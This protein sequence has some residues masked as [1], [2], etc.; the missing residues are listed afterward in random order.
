MSGGKGGSSTSE[1]TIP[2]YSEAA[3]QRNLN[4][5]E[6][7]S[8]IGYTP[9]YGPDVAAFTPMQQAAFQNTADTAGAFGMAAPTSQQD[10]MGGMAAPTEYAGGV[11]GYS[12]APMYE[13][14]LAELGRQ[15]PGQKEYIDSFFINPRTGAAG[16]NMQPMVDYTQYGTMAQ[17]ARDTGAA[18]RANDLA[19]AQA[20][21]GAGP[22]SVYNFTPQTDV[23]V[24]GTNVGVGGTTV[25]GTNVGV[26]GQ[27]TQYYNPDIN[28]EG[29]TTSPSTNETV[30]VLQPN[31]DAVDAM[32]NEY[33]IDPNFYNDPSN[34]IYSSS[35]FPLG[36][37]LS[38]T[39]YTNYSSVENTDSNTASN[40]FG[41]TVQTGYDVGQVDPALAAAAGYTA[42]ET[43]E[44]YTGIADM[45]NGG[46]PNNSGDTYSGGGVISDLG[47]SVATSTDLPGNV[48][49]RAL[50][51][52]A[53]KKDESSDSGYAGSSDDGCVVATH[54]VESGAFTPSMK[55]EAV[56]WCMNV[57]HGKWWGEAIRRGYRHC[58]NKKIAKGKAR[59]H[60]SEFRRYI[61]FARGKDRTL[62]GA[63]TFTIRTAQFFAVGLVKRDA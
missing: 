20:Q 23:V 41:S 15:R 21:A 42:P 28:Y 43:S 16:P 63:I 9:Y 13:E 37:S 26:G 11:R 35:D 39:D 60:Y 3:A 48:I 47:N 31:S 51:V 4:K 61:A 36:S 27:S 10:I 5:A 55:R 58:G 62:R 6:G 7:I 22:Q 1:V 40:D 12:S 8:Q 46:G 29:A 17:D 53:G 34:P 38:G 54:A 19:I 2:E 57:L 45:L 33:G 52:G 24:G 32:A 14:S 56:V 25:G 44:G 59:E 49:S 30:G 18:N 50:N